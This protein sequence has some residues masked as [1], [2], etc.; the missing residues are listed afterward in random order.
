MKTI[1]TPNNKLYISISALVMICFPAF[2]V[3]FITGDSSLAACFSLFYMVN[4]IYSLIIGA[5]SGRNVKKSWFNP[6]LS[7]L[8][9]YIGVRV[10]I[11]SS[12][13]LFIKYS[14][15]YLLIG[16]ISMFISYYLCTKLK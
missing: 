1:N 12:D 6:I 8:F 4:P 14:I 3:L 16:L 2:C 5:I 9:F 11:G 15:I 10:F 13:P 7:A